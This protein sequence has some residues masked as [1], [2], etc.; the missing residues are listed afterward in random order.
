MPATVI[1]E[2][3][4]A[5]LAPPKGGRKGRHKS[6]AAHKAVIKY[7]KK[8]LSKPEAWKRIMG[9]FKNKVWAE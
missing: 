5:G 2:Y 1:K 6:L 7:M 3:K 8:G 9:S 4:K